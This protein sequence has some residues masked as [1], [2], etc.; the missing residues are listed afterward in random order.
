MP[1]SLRVVYRESRRI[2]VLA[3]ESFA[4]MLEKHVYEGAALGS[5]GPNT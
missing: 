4:A 2:L 5:R 1:Y 3:I